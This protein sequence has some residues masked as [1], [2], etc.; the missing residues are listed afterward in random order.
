NSSTYLLRES[1]PPAS[2]ERPLATSMVYVNA[3]GPGHFATL[4]IAMIEGRDFTAFDAAN[5]PAVAIVNETLARRFWPG[6]SAIG[7]RWRPLDPRAPAS[8]AT[9]VVGVV[10]DSKYVTLGE[11]ARPFL[12]RPIAQAY[13]PLVTLLIRAD[14]P[15]RTAVPAL[16]RAVQDVDA[17]LAV[18]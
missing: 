9:E 15:P 11:E 16:T 1:D 3:V 4:Q 7:R 6:P 12:Y 13:V 2:A 8:A 17:G 18:F 14:G 5:R 10:K